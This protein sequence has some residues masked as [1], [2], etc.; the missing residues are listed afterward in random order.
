VPVTVTESSDP[1]SL[2]AIELE[3]NIRRVDLTWQERSV[4]EKKL[5][6]LR[7][8]QHGEYD[9][10]L[11]PAGWSLAKTS[12]EIDPEGKGVGSAHREVA[13]NIELADWVN[14]PDIAKIKDKK[15][16]LKAARDKLKREA[17]TSHAV[18][19]FFNASSDDYTYKIG[20]V[21]DELALLPDASI[22]VFLSDPPY[23]RNFHHDKLWS[24][25]RRDFNDSPKAY[26]DLMTHLFEVLALKLKPQAHLYLF[27]DIFHFDWLRTE[28]ALGVN[29]KTWRH[30][31][32]WDK[33]HYGS[34][35]EIEFGPRHCYDII[36]FANRNDRPILK[37]D[38]DVISNIHH[39]MDK[40]HPDQ[41]PSEL[42]RNL[43]LRS[44]N[45]GDLVVDG[46]A[47]SGTIFQA[48][49][50]LSLRVFAIEQ[51]PQWESTIQAN[52][53]GNT[54]NPGDLF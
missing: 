22:D 50:D 15:A 1:L 16:A 46:F 17:R 10:K 26:K 34:Y 3:D 52:I 31:I 13:E 14:D 21:I 44:A 36:L 18:E 37:H 27:C 38:R 32:I 23:G 6:D 30:P 11:N 5:H 40:D 45:P 20:D 9:P 41:K 2:I 33:S 29:I 25:L 51:D 53:R 12:R 42:F 19:A 49:K 54:N 4:A 48:A 39:L 43:L 24:G 28:L 7:I 47:G 8:S 35:A